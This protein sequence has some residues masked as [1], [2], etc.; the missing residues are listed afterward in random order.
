MPT[1]E[2]GDP[3][4]SEDQG[5]NPQAK[6][7]E[8]ATQ[9]PKP[10]YHVG[11]EVVYREPHGNLIVATR[12]TENYKGEMVEGHYYEIGDE[13]Q[14]LQLIGFQ[15]GPIP[16][17]GRNGVTNEALIAIGIHRLEL[18]NAKFPC[19]ENVRAISGLKDSLAALEERTAKRIA[20]GVEGKLVA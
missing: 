6:F 4:P 10:K 3:V 15:N 8:Y 16:E 20:R 18:M 2:Y 11:S 19:D 9:V 5:L 1:P 14:C 13:D 12:A 17:A 7:N